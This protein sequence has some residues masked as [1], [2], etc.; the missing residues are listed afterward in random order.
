MTHINM[1]GIKINKKL[2]PMKMHY[3]LYSGC[4]YFLN[5]WAIKNLI[6][7]YI[8]LLAPWIL[9]NKIYKINNETA[10]YNG[11]LINQKI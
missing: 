5:I 2:L 1:L 10:A 6:W 7:R 11:I 9:K 4:E 3:F 8:H